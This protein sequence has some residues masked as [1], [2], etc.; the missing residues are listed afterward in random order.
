VL[1]DVDLS[2]IG[3]LVEAWD[4]SV[5][6][7]EET[8]DRRWVKIIGDG[9]RKVLFYHETDSGDVWL[10]FSFWETTVG[11]YDQ[12]GINFPGTLV[13]EFGQRLSVAYLE[14]ERFKGYLVFKNE[15][16]FWGR[17]WFK[18]SDTYFCSFERAPGGSG[19]NKTEVFRIIAFLDR[20]T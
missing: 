19:A 10:S 1:K 5:E 4:L 12:D 8:S 17:L 6:N 16:E 18:L 2:D 3:K 20:T 9:E 13:G 14:G 11:R 7:L 15:R